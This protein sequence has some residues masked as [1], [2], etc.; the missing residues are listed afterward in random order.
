[1][2]IKRE[3]R[4]YF[5]GNELID[6][7]ILDEVIT[8]SVCHANVRSFVGAFIVGKECVANGVV[9]CVLGIIGRGHACVAITDRR[10]GLN[11]VALL[12]VEQCEYC[13]VFSSTGSAC[14]CHFTEVSTDRCEGVAFFNDR[15]KAAVVAFGNDLVTNERST[16]TTGNALGN[17][18]TFGQTEYG[19]TNCFCVSVCCGKRF[20]RVVH[21]VERTTLDTGLDRTV[22]VIEGKEST[23]T[24][25][26]EYITVVSGDLTVTVRFSTGGL[27]CCAAEVGEQNKAFQGVV[28]FVVT[29]RFC[30]DACSETVFIDGVFNSKTEKRRFLFVA[31][32]T[33]DF[34]VFFEL[35]KGVFRA[36][37]TD[38]LF[39]V[40]LSTFT[41][42]HQNVH[43]CAVVINEE[44]VGIGTFGSGN[45]LG[46][47]NSIFGSR[48]YKGVERAGIED[49]VIDL[50]FFTGHFTLVESEN[51]EDLSFKSGLFDPLRNKTL[52]FNGTE[53]IFNTNTVREN[54]VS[55]LTACHRSIRV[56]EHRAGGTGFGVRIGKD[57]LRKESVT[58]LVAIAGGCRG[59]LCIYGNVIGVGESIFPALEILKSKFT[60]LRIKIES[61]SVFFAFIHESHGR[62]LCRLRSI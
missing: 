22:C 50:E 8:V 37:F 38:E 43:L 49:T 21:A 46:I 60:G 31:F 20:K 52:G 1:M 5:A 2:D 56:A 32:I 61:I 57:D 53:C 12:D 19:N 42:T 25:G 15:N 51:V 48:A 4:F 35:I 33:C 3:R 10:T 45:T 9:A 41:D 36:I 18:V 29:D 26:N 58:D 55:D 16:F 47:V 62:E 40:F 13:A 27:Q 44:L 14:P 24:V 30:G 28:G 6:R 11:G 39:N 23:G 59:R 34:V 17:F 7:A 54:L